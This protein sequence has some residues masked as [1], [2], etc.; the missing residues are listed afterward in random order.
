MLGARGLGDRQYTFA[1]TLTVSETEP[2]VNSVPIQEG[3]MRLS[4]QRPRCRMTPAG[5]AAYETRECRNGEAHFE[6]HISAGF[7]GAPRNS[8]LVRR[9]PNT[10]FS[11]T[12]RAAGAASGDH[13]CVSRA[14]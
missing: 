1:S 8:Y 5:G 3:L 7:D 14:A 13:A 2:V 4:S 11:S 12:L 9:G 10:G 6:V